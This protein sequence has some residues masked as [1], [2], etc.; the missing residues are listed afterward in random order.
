MKMNDSDFNISA[1]ENVFS[2]SENITIQ[3]K[4][5]KVRNYDSIKLILD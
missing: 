4:Q 1:F 2:I 3:T 5:I